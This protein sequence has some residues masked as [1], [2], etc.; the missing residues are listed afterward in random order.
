MADQ[1]IIELIGDPSGLK[2]AEEALKSLSKVSEENKEAFNKANEAF[3]K[4]TSAAVTAAKAAKDFN[5]NSKE[6]NKAIEGIGTSATKSITAISGLNGVIAAG[7]V[8]ETT[9]DYKDWSKEIQALTTKKEVLNTK[10]E[11]NRQAL[12]ISKL[13]GDKTSEVYQKL[14]TNSQSLGGQISSNNQK[15]EKLSAQYAQSAKAATDAGTAAEK[16]A[17]K[18]KVMTSS[19]E[20]GGKS[21]AKL[22]GHTKDLTSAMGE[23]GQAIAHAS[24]NEEAAIEIKKNTES[25]I[26]AIGVAQT[27]V[28][29]VTEASTMAT[30]ANTIATTIFGEAAATAWASATMGISVLIGL[31]VALGSNIK[32]ITGWLKEL[33]SPLSVQLHNKELQDTITKQQ[34]ISEEAA[35]QVSLMEAAGKSATEI[36]DKKREQLEADQKLLRAQLEL[37][38]SQGDTTK[39]KETQNKL[40]ENAVSLIRN[41]KEGEEAILKDMKEEGASNLQILQTKQKQN[42]SSLEAVDT[43]LKRNKADAA[44]LDIEIARVKA[45]GTLNLEQKLELAILEGQSAALKK[46]S[47]EL[48]H[49]NKVLNAQKTEITQGL[50]EENAKYLSIAKD[51]ADAKLSMTKAGSKEELDAKIA[52]L[53]AAAAVEV[54]NALGNRIR[55]A[56]IRQ[57]LNQDTAAA[58]KE[59]ELQKLQNEK[60]DL[61]ASLSLDSTKEKD[62]LAIRQHILEIEHTLEISQANLTANQKLLIDQEYKKK[63]KALNA[64]PKNEADPAEAERKEKLKKEAD[65][66]KEADK[67]ELNAHI[68]LAKAKLANEDQYSVEAIQIRKNMLADQMQLQIDE[69]N[70]TITNADELK[71]KVLEIEAQYQKDSQQIDDDKAKHEKQNADKIL[72]AKKDAAKKEEDILKQVAAKAIEAAKQV[73]DAIFANAQQRRDNE[74]KATEDNLNAQKNAELLNTT[75]TASQRQAIE[76]KYKAEEA[77]AKLQAWKADQKAKEEQAIINGLLAFTTALAQQ[78]YPA[79]LVTGLLALAQAG[80]QAGIIASKTAPKFAAGVID[81]QGP[82]TAT[83][84]S[85]PAFLSRGESVMT[86]DET[87]RFKPVLEAMRAGSFMDSYIPKVNLHSL[88]EGT[89]ATLPRESIDYEKLGK[90]IAKNTPHPVSNNITIDKNG[91]KVF[92]DKGGNRT[93]FL[94]N[95][96]KL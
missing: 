9:K 2:P 80:V 56:A 66:Q 30:E 81:L 15:L 21:T 1:I 12:L 94:N 17:S 79:G 78:G 74:L 59:F 47:G 5:E 10:L 24:G 89:G 3:A 18:F 91:F 31:V 32:A 40:D 7:V 16:G 83:S 84:D 37:A 52:D 14:I 28:T 45:K 54:N 29:A 53:N 58:L 85:I 63:V 88:L 26:K 39:I 60:T 22:L 65:E 77:Q 42:Q 35:R 87:R 68:S 93:E 51:T 86:A 57:K 62:K 95:N 55:V 11:K 27:V 76:R 33:F 19:I 36:N 48:E 13:A 20:E 72:Q 46:Q 71:A 25:A 8:K 69:A 92:T 82:G 73:S 75:L 90:V 70:N 6:T 50:N 96:S 67:S 44:A 4:F 34:K 41:K 43:A 49:Q 61:E 64:E 38:K 23:I